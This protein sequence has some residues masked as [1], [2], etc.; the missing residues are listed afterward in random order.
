MYDIS[1]EALPYWEGLTQ[2]KLLLQQCACCHSVRHYPRPMCPHCHAM[3]STWSPASGLGT[4]HSWTI[5]HQTGLPGFS[6]RVPYVLATVDLAE[7]VRML[8]PLV[9]VRAEDLRIGMPVEIRFEQQGDGAVIPVF[10][11]INSSEKNP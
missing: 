11:N 3:A 10:V 1:I 5:T 2:K 4:V 8:A 6:E 9:K 7:G